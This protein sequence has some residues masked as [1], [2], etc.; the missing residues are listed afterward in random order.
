MSDSLTKIRN[1]VPILDCDLVCYRVGFACEKDEPIENVLHSV[2]LVVANALAPFA[3]K[4]ELYISGKGNFRNDIAVTKPYKGNRV[5]TPKPQYYNEIREYL[6]N[7]KG[8]IP[9]DGIEPDD[10]QGI[11]QY[12]LKGKGCIVSI[13]KDMKMIKGW[14]YNFVKQEAFFVDGLSADRWFFTQLLTGDPTDNIQGIPKVG[15]K[16]AEKLLN[17]GASPEEWL[18]ICEQEYQRYYGEDEWQSKLSEMA[19]LLWILRKRDTPCPW[20]RTRLTRAAHDARPME[21]QSPAPFMD[22]E[23]PTTL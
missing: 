4:A 13:D 19:G 15:P 21:S 16:T 20:V 14:H 2:K 3:N 8:A 11:R 22:D 10:M 17:A 9:T 18:A 6:I 5:D 1:L 7:V 12:E 23:L